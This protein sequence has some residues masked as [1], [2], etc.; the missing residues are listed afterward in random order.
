[1]PRITKAHKRESII[2]FSK[3][4]IGIIK[5][6][7]NLDDTIYGKVIPEFE[8][9]G[10]RYKLRKNILPDHSNLP[11]NNLLEIL[12]QRHNYNNCGPDSGKDQPK[13]NRINEQAFIYKEGENAEIVSGKDRGFII[14]G[15]SVQCYDK[16]AF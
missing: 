10:W 15:F 4:A 12:I 2:P 14:D 6:K 13:G 11:E 1:M 16:R 3:E 5:D 8:K 7:C 9:D